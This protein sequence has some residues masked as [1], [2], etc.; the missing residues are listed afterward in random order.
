[1]EGKKIA[2]LFKK[3]IYCRA[4]AAVFIREKQC[5]NFLFWNFQ[6]LERV[7]KFQRIFFLDF[8]LFMIK[9]WRAELDFFVEHDIRLFKGHLYGKRWAFQETSAAAHLTHL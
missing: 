5:S 8:F 7:L 9:T 3:S 6:N 1:M 2:S 4:A